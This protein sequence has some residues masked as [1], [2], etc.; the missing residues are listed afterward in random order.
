LLVILTGI[1]AGLAGGLLMRLF[2]SVQHLAYSYSSGEDDF[3]GAVA[4][5]SG[6]RR[7]LMLLGAGVLAAGVRALLHFTGQEGGGDLSESIWFHSGRLPFF[8]TCVRGLL[9]IVVVGMGVSLGRE[10]A[11][12]QTG[13]A[14]A[15]TLS[16]WFAV[17]ASQQRLLVACAAGAGMAAAYNVP[18][19]GAMFAV[20]VLLG[21]LVL[22]TVIP[23]LATSFIATA[24]SWLLLPNEPTYRIP[25]YAFHISNVVWA[26]LTAPVFGFTAVVWVR[27]IV[28]ADNAKP[29]NWKAYV[30]PAFVFVLLGIPAVWFPDIL[31]NGKGLVQRTYTNQL[32]LELLIPLLL[33]KFVA[34]PGCLSSG[35]P[36]GLFTPTLTVGALLGAVLGHLWA[37]FVPASELGVFA[38]IG[39]VAVL[40]AATQGPIS[41]VAFLIELT[42]RVDALMVPVL[43]A[44]VGASLLAQR[45]ENRSVYSARVRKGMRAAQKMLLRGTSFDHLATE[46]FSVATSAATLATVQRRLLT[47]G[48]PL[49]VIDNRGCLVGAISRDVVADAQCNIPV[50]TMT[51]ADL[52]QPTPPIPSSA[53]E[54]D[55]LSAFRHQARKVMPVVDSN[56]GSLL[57]AIEEPGG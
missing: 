23:A 36:G 50:E 30:A 37:M 49:F 20:E 43:L 9:S 8:R 52:A 3:L 35:V 24:V 1:G 39:S 10:G 53:N 28:W 19:G 29:K 31:G 55:V 16:R 33:I 32:G 40:A 38:I 21:T 44:I 5:V 12:K 2:H 26:C 15:S 6:L 46:K 14:I 45:F 48:E 34:A 51:A 7:V 25:S 11:L 54:S 13:A 47:V 4:H 18:F 41:A 56:S 27:A 22:P 42:H 57:G 17:P